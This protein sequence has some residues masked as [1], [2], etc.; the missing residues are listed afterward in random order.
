M[1]FQILGPG[2]NEI[3]ITPSLP[4]NHQGKILPLHQP[5]HA[6]AHFGEILFQHY[7]GNGFTIWYSN[8]HFH[9]ATTLQGRADI[10][11]L[12]LHIQFLN[13][14]SN[15]WDGLHQTVL[16]PYQYNLSFT[17]H[18]LNHASF[19]GGKDYHTF[20]IHFQKT[21]LEKLAPFFP[22]L[23]QFLYKIN[24][25]QPTA[26]SPFD[27]FLSHEMIAIVNRLLNC[28]FTNEAASFFIET[29][30]EEL[31]LLVL[32]HTAD[33]HPQ[34]PIVLDKYDQEQIYEAKN[35]ILQEIENP[36]SLIQL[37]RKVGLND[38]KLKKG[39]KLMFGTTVFNYLHQERMNTAHKLL[40]ETSKTIDH[41]AYEVGYEHPSNF[42]LAFK[43]QFGYTAAYLRK[44]GRG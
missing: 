29:K 13:S 16:K 30:V 6:A 18:V 37:A 20:D 41:I 28:P 8:Y 5:L 17:P 7:I 43:K 42:N 1:E 9:H 31:L 14:F 34:P 27:R 4:K 24:R 3:I 2:A 38:Y 44:H 21:Y 11:V 36:P 32:N 25:D 35:I 40:L 19:Q 12:E 10:P 22:V 39:F 15:Q 26:I 23:D 33:Q